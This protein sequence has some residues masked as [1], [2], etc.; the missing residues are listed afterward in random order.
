MLTYRNVWVETSCCIRRIPQTS[1]YFITMVLVLVQSVIKA[2]MMRQN[3]F[4]CL[5]KI[6]RDFFKSVLK[7]I[8]PKRFF[9]METMSYC[10]KNAGHIIQSFLTPFGI[11]YN[12]HY[13]HIILYTKTSQQQYLFAKVK[14]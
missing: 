6:P 5:W 3:H 2:R 10:S 12:Y 8:E 7:K 9:R 11:D 14:L 4:C 1:F 13:V